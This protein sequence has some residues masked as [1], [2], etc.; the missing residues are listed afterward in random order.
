MV[1][2]WGNFSSRYRR[3]NARRPAA[4]EENDLVQLPFRFLPLEQRHDGHLVAAPAFVAHWSGASGNSNSD[5]TATT[6]ASKG[7]RPC[8]LRVEITCGDNET[9]EKENGA[10][11]S[12]SIR[13]CAFYTTQNVMVVTYRNGSAT[14]HR[15]DRKRPRRQRSPKPP[16]SSSGSGMGDDSDDDS[17]S[18]DGEDDSG[19]EA[20]QDSGSGSRPAG[21]TLQ[22]VARHARVRDVVLCSILNGFVLCPGQCVADAYHHFFFFSSFFFLSL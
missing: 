5:K 1:V 8:E 21:H 6:G 16:T 11:P 3:L 22:Q 14:V 15:L 9:E 2:A 18:S 4:D 7:M 13:S 20:G 17:D 19:T 12:T 10:A